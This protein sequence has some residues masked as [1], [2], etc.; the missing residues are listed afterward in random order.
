[1]EYLFPVFVF[2]LQKQIKSKGDAIL[3]F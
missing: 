1:M 2:I 3:C